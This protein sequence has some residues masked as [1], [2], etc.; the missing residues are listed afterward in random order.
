MHRQIDRFLIVDLHRTRTLRE[1][2]QQGTQC[3]R[4]SRSISAQQRHDLPLADGEIYTV[5]NMRLAV[6]SVQTRDAK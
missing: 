5:Q 3:R 1:Q 4:S 2:T 6:V